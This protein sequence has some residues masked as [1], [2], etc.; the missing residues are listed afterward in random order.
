MKS[1]CVICFENVDST[2][3]IKKWECPH[4]FHESCIEHWDHDCPLCRNTNIILPEITWTL[5]HNPECPLWM[6][7]IQSLAHTVLES[8]IP[9]YHS[10][11]KDQDCIT[12]QHNMC[13][14]Q[15]NPT[16]K[17]EIIGIC[18]DCNTCQKFV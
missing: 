1:N 2:T 8:K 3:L 15:M 10:L 17:G 9:L 11:W 13:Y 4:L 18:E 12:N 5:S 6:N 14:Y 16:N 7:Q